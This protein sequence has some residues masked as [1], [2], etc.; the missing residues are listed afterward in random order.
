MRDFDLL[1]TGLDG[2]LNDLF[3]SPA[4]HAK[5]TWTNRRNFQPP[6]DIEE[7]EQHFLISLDVPGVDKKDIK[8]EV[9]NGELRVSG[10][11]KIERHSKDK[12]WTFNERVEGNFLRSFSLGDGVDA[13]KIEATYRD[14]VLY[15]AIEKTQKTRS[16]EIAI[17][18]SPVATKA[19]NKA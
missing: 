4:H 15:L 12:G 2:F 14:G 7:S 16:R 3:K 9:V 19:L 1:P 6:V 8:I 5:D 11:R 10:Q 13:D 18:D 17:S